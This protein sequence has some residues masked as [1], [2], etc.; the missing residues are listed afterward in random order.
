MPTEV[1]SFSCP[2]CKKG[3]FRSLPGPN[4]KAYC[5]WCGEAVASGSPTS[6]PEPGPL[7]EFSLEDI[8]TRIAGKISNPPAAPASPDLEARLAESERKREAVEAELKRELDKK[9][10]IK[11]MVLSEVGRLEAELADARNRIRR[12]DEEHASAL[13]SLNLLT[14]AKTDEINGERMRFQDAVDEKDKALQALEARFDERQKSAVELQSML[15][16]SRA[17]VGRLHAEV[18]A[19]Q[20]ERS[21]LR[22]K[23]SAAGAKVES[24][25]DAGAQL[26]G[27]RLRLKESEAKAAAQQAEL[28]KKDQRLKELQLLVKTLGE[29]LNDLADRAPGRGAPGA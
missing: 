20:A 5:P 17:E 10:E 18:A 27:V 26:D 24:L 6:V 3:E 22:R 19:A 28:Q 11:R 29:R 13:Q 15:D 12:K 16:A 2:R 25:K 23:L 9:Q 7:P 21:E 8:A 1:Q 4:G 14:G